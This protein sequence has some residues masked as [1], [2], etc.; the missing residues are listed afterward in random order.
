VLDERI[1][2]KGYQGEL[3]QVTV[4]ELGHE[5]PTILLTNNFKIHC[6]A[7]VTRY[8]QRMLGIARHSLHY[9]PP[10]HAADAGGHLE[11]T[12]LRLAADHPAGAD[13][14]VPH[15]QGAR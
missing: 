2:L 12:C 15:S 1:V 7:L 3:R 9:P 4:I 5:E 10:A 13:P 8:A 11:P 6:P 14:Q